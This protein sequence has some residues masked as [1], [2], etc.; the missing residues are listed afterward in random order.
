MSLAA[1]DFRLGDEPF[2]M[3]ADEPPVEDRRRVSA[4]RWRGRSQLAAGRRSFKNSPERRA[5]RLGAHEQTCTA[6]C[7]RACTARASESRPNLVWAS[8]Q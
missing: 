7:R 6:R 5:R 8:R 3:S 1:V 4:S 2:P